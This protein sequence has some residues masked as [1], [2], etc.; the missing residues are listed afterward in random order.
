MTLK[1]SDANINEI[2]T[3]EFV[4]IDFWAEWC[5][6]CRMLGPIIDEVSSE[7]TDV[8]IG[9]LNVADN[10]I[11]SEYGITSIPCLV[12]FKNGIEVSRHKGVLS[13]AALLSKIEELKK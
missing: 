11:S 4:I 9:K 3:N 12:F 8:T 7:V 10:V 1:I 6:P 2:L 13:K 5:G